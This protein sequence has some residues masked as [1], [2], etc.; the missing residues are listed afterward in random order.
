MVSDIIKGLAQ[1]KTALI[2]SRN[3]SKLPFKLKGIVR[4][5]NEKGQ[6]LGIVFDQ[7]TL[8]DIRESEEASDPRF[9][10]ELEDSRKSGSVAGEDIEKRL[11]LR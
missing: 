3:L 11:G 1:E 10:A 2:H 7:A 8:E 5:V 6:T 9:W 4:L